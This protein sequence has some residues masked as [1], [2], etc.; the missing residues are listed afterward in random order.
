MQR[1]VDDRN[2]QDDFN[3]PHHLGNAVSDHFRGLRRS[4]APVVHIVIALLLSLLTSFS[5]KAENARSYVEVSAGYMTGDFGTPTKSNLNYLSSTIGYIAPDYD[6]SVTV[7]YLSFTSKTGSQSQTESGVGDMILRFGRVLVHEGA[8]GLSLDGALSVKIPT[9]DEM[10]GLGTGETDYGAFLGLRQRL[11]GF[12]VSFHGGYIKVGDP[13]HVN[14]N[15]I[16]LYGIGISGI[17]GFTELYTNYEG[18][19]ATVPGAKNPQEI[20]IGFFHVLNTD[21]A[22]KGSAFTGL[23]NGGP[24]LGFN[25]GL[26]RWF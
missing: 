25:A 6:V 24:D 13:P 23:N 17:F 5:A 4:S 20:Y 2:G 21:Y 19:Q 3:S 11:G 16:Y 8:G 1:P 18:R 7:P 14:Y 22:I 9:A 12:K 26:V 15:D 10:K